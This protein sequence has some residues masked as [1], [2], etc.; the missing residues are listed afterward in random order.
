MK[1][2]DVLGGFKPD[3]A[4]QHGCAWFVWQEGNTDP[5]KTG[6]WAS[7][8][9]EPAFAFASPK[10]LPSNVVW[11]T[12]L[13]KAQTWSLGKW[14]HIKHGGFLG[15]EW[16]TLM[17]EW[18]FP[19][20][21][22]EFQQSCAFWSEVLARMAEWLS[23]W[24]AQL[25]NPANNSTLPPASASS[26]WHWGDGDLSDALADR[27]AWVEPKDQ[28]HPALR[29]AYLEQVEQEWPH[30]A[31]NGKRK[32]ALS[33][34]RRP[35]ARQ[36]LATRFPVGQFT[37]VPSG[38]LPQ[39]QDK[40]WEWMLGQHLPLLVRFDDI[41]FKQGHE[42][43]AA[44]WWGRRGRK[45]SG[46]IMEPVWM[47]AE[48]ALQ[49]SEFIDA[50]P[51]V[52][53]RAP[54]WRRLDDVPFWPNMDEDPILDNSLL[55]GL[56]GEALWRAAST[57]ARTLTKRV[58]SGVS[59]RMIWWRSADRRACFLAAKKVHESGFLVM[60]YG[61]G[62]VHAAFDP[63]TTLL[64]DWEKLVKEV[65]VSP[66]LAIASTLPQP[67]TLDALS[68]GRW[69][70]SDNSLEPFLLLDRLLWP[71]LGPQKSALKP[72]LEHAMRS[73]INRPAPTPEWS[74]Q[75]KTQLKAR[76]KEGIQFIT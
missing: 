58:K 42:D 18:G 63:S 4:R 70:K 69:L 30:H 53:L 61:Q 39:D 14:S 54:G 24:N 17:S 56:L 9:G 29:A 6:G 5:S 45:F 26:Q 27:L 65:R 37:E 41:T 21:L 36:L 20:S 1:H 25:N 10:D 22:E 60:S 35:H 8:G 48:E 11:W 66:P 32:L 43:L 71:W 47:P 23:R 57:P 12:N 55:G 33:L 59:P 52:F 72:I 76:A 40:R 68:M 74:T 64:A 46:A 3:V 75:W 49:M 19:S 7:V 16:L 62:V 28:H 50:Y 38:E 34:P 13:T 73:L 2:E 44:L 67:S 15:P 31:L 51:Q